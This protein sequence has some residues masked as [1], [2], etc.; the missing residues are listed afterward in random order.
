MS[1]SAAR[2]RRGWSE[3][4]F[5]ALA[6]EAS[7]SGVGSRGV[8]AGMWIVG[9]SGMGDAERE[10]CREPA[11][12][13][14]GEGTTDGGFDPARELAL[15]PAR[16]DAAEDAAEGAFEDFGERKGNQEPFPAPAPCAT[17][18]MAS[19]SRWRFS[20]FSFFLAF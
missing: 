4:Q 17:A 8:S 1:S 15:D 19:R 10:G 7:S 12:D 14:A 16:E 13:R 11:L 3:V 18:S 5:F 9:T 6:S 20:F 2:G